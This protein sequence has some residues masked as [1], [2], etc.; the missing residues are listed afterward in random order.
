MEGDRERE[1][2]KL[3]GAR[4][5]GLFPS[6]MCTRGATSMPTL[7]GGAA[8]ECA[9]G[10]SGAGRQPDLCLTLASGTS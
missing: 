2:G 7:T 8:S 1:T 5:R 4:L 3:E 6:T 10:T 9:Q